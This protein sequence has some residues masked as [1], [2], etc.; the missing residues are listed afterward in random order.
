MNRHRY[1]PELRPRLVRAAE[2]Y[3]NRD[4]DA[5]R[6]ALSQAIDLAP[7]RLDLRL[8]LA[9]HHIQCGEFK[10]ALDIWRSLLDLS[11]RDV[12]AMTYM[13]HWTRFLGSPERAEYIRLRLVAARP[14]RATELAH[15]WETI[16]AWEKRR[17][18]TYESAVGAPSD[19]PIILVLGYKLDPDGSIHPQLLDRLETALE[20][21]SR[22]PASRVL[23][24][25]GVPRNGVVEAVVMRKWFESRGVDSSVIWEEGYSRD[26]VE[27]ML[28][29]RQI[30]DQQNATCVVVVT[31]AHNVR[32]AGA[33]LEIVGWMH[34]AAWTVECVSSSQS[35]AK[36]LD[37]GADREKLY[38][39]SL[40]AYGMPMMG[41]YPEL[42]AL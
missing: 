38:R 31:A 40:R 16:D 10:E 36:Y 35:H 4:D 32:R 25:G 33:A 9:N 6:E 17:I 2:A 1:S 42:I 30:L 39:D 20:L 12:E 21:H 22:L 13:A 8:D 27:N 15:I 24:S 19:D 3:R 5:F 29:S 41:T 18:A 34:G 7:D 23:V 26:V 37:T 14:E 11:R 28:Y